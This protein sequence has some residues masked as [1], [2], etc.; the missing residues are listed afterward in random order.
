MKSRFDKRFYRY[1]PTQKEKAKYNRK[2]EK[3]GSEYRHLCEE[4]LG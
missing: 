1:K 4:R 3:T 2:E